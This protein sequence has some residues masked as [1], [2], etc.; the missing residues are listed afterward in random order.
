MPLALFGLTLF[1]LGWAV[2]R[3]NL[4]AATRASWPWKL[5]LLDVQSA[6]T[7]ATIAGGLIFARAQYAA[8][9]R[10]AI[11]WS[12]GWDKGNWIVRLSNGSPIPS[13]FLYLQYR[14]ESEGGSFGST[15]G[16]WVPH[17]TAEDQLRALGLQDGEDFTIRLFGPLVPMSGTIDNSLRI[18]S[19]S[20]QAISRLKDVQIRVRAQDQ[21]GDIH[22]RIVYCFRGL[23]GDEGSL[24]D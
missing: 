5:Q 11:S 4:P 9:V 8:A 6:T 7:A 3:L 13:Y 1:L 23:K 22:Q 15:E 16:P 12:G 17:D 21:A 20:E 14:I 19:F 2:V 10:P 18:A 24:L